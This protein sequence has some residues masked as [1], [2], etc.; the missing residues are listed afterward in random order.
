[1][2]CYFIQMKSLQILVYCNVIIIK[3]ELLVHAS[4]FFSFWS[5]MV[6]FLAIFNLMNSQP[7]YTE[8]LANSYFPVF[9]NTRALPWIFPDKIIVKRQW[10]VD[11]TLRFTLL[12][13]FENFK[14]IQ[15]FNSCCFS[16]GNHEAKTQN[17]LIPTLKLKLL[18][19]C[20][21]PGIKSFRVQVWPLLWLIYVLHFAQLCL[22]EFIPNK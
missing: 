13:K 19:F 11:I 10:R 1:M 16:Y 8:A 12:W 2:F 17:P 18:S 21:P 15:I 4:N 9:W 20:F 3:L 22:V 6:M 14:F 5:I 7:C